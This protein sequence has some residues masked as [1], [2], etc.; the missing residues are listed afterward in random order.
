MD[1]GEFMKDGR[2]VLVIPAYQ[3][4]DRLLP[5]LKE[6]KQEGVE[7]I[8]LVDDGGK[9]KYAHYFKTAKEEYGCEVFT[10]AVNLGKGRAL[11]DA[12]NYCLNNYPDLLGCVT[13]DSDG[14]HSIKNIKECMAALRENPND[15]I[16]GCRNFNDESVPWKSRFGNKISIFV[17]KFFAGV[18]VSDTQTGLRAIPKD[19]MEELMNVPGER[20][21][22][23]TNMLIATKNNRRIKE[24]TI[25]TIYD[26]KE[27]HQTHFNPI[28]D[29]FKIYKLYFKE[30]FKFMFSSLSS[31]IIDLGLFHHLCEFLLARKVNKYVLIATIIARI[32]SSI[33]NYYV[34]KKLVFKTKSNTLKTLVRYTLL[35]VVQGLASGYLCQLFVNLLSATGKEVLIKIPVDILLFLA[36]YLIQREYVYKTEKIIVL[37]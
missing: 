16:I 26:S 13:A 24:I 8:V 12:F 34:N 10:H 36:S 7:D 19:F 11:K 4:D 15:L 6:A 22:F 5:L 1:V 25:E 28:T 17:C 2:I 37:K 29:S 35:V 3:P 23:E 32:I 33:Y 30:F 21:E 14:Q 31:S 20:F 9:E 27:N 18:S